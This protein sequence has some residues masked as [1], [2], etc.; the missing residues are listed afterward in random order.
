MMYKQNRH[1]LR[2]KEKNVIV[3]LLFLYLYIIQWVQINES[4]VQWTMNNK[5]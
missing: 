3:D 1:E 4:H 5:I 2:S